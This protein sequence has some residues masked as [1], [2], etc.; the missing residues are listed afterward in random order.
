MTRFE[1]NA[2]STLI[3]YLPNIAKQLEIANKLKAI[4][5][6][7]NID[8]SVKEPYEWTKAIDTALNS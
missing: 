3:Y 5:L 1:D 7:R 8:K 4:E 6:K 2:Y